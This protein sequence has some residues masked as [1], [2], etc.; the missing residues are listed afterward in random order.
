MNAKLDI[1]IIKKQIDNATTS[2]KDAIKRESSPDVITMLKN[3][4]KSLKKEYVLSVHVTEKGEPRKINRPSNS[5]TIKGWYTRVAGKK[6]ITASSEEG[7]LEKLY[8][9]Y[10]GESDD[11]AFNSAFQEFLKFLAND[12]KTTNGT[13]CK[14][15]SN[16]KRFVNERMRNMDIRDVSKSFLREYTNE[17]LKNEHF[18]TKTF[19][20]YKS[21]FNNFF[22]FCDEKYE[23]IL[24]PASNLKSSDYKSHLVARKKGPE[25]KAHSRN[26]IQT[27]QNEAWARINASLEKKK[28]DIYPFVFLLSTETGPRLG[29]LFS[30]KM[31]DIKLS[32]H[33]LHIH[34]QQCFDRIT[35]QTYILDYTRNEKG[36]AQGGRYEPIS[37]ALEIVLSK[38][39]AYKKEFG[40]ESEYVFPKINGDYSIKANY[41]KWLTRFCNKCKVHLTNNH[42][43]R[44]YFNSYVLEDLEVPVAEK[45]AIMGHSVRVNLDCYTHPDHSYCDNTYEK[46]LKKH[47]ERMNEPN[48]IPFLG[49]TM[50][51]GA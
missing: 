20:E 19:S 31:A 11:L 14:Y 30:L 2:L 17:L 7:L 36:I 1:S 51:K 42:A 32:K 43:V 13:I 50:Q 29:E 3:E 12:A 34:S 24:N 26:D 48:I 8:K 37:P 22:L 9:Y 49:D 28:Y 40:V 38:L 39:A 18:T 41:D 27:L 15:R 44:M 16:Y 25:E 35:K 46:M 45:A 21:F 33:R 6:R 4:I 5:N 23:G 10:T 47:N